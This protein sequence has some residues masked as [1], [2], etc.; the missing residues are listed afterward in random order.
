MTQ[1]SFL[2][3]EEFF[4]VLVKDMPKE[5]VEAYDSIRH[6][7]VE[8]AYKGK[9]FAV[10]KMQDDKPIILGHVKVKDFVCNDE[11]GGS[12]VLVWE[13]T[14]EEVEVGY[15]PTQLFGFNLFVH[16]PLDIKVRWTTR[17]GKALSPLL[18]FLMVV[19]SCS[20]RS[21]REPNVVYFESMKTFTREFGSDA[22]A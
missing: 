10:Y 15:V 2:S 14:G 4:E 17:R 22:A 3:P 18:S 21:L 1:S 5:S 19:R 6:T 11:D 7:R 16:L 9:R 13:K 8:P 20:R 12:T